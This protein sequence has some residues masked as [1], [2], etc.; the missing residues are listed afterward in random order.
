METGD[1]ACHAI[2]SAN[3]LIFYSTIHK[4]FDGDKKCPGLRTNE[5]SN[6]SIVG[7]EDRVV[8][9]NDYAD[10]KNKPN[11]KITSVR[12]S[13]GQCD[14]KENGHH[15]LCFFISFS[16]LLSTEMLTEF[17]KILTLSFS[18]AVMENI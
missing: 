14:C 3:V 18:C 2:H 10:K 6:A 15:I 16:Y 11:N 13:C 4:R 12:Y 17:A 7:V 9:G 1:G 5:A 8:Y